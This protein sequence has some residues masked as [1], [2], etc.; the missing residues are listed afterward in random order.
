MSRPI[1]SWLAL[2]L[3]MLSL[4]TSPAGAALPPRPEG[5]VLDQAAVIPDA[6]EV[7]LDRKLRDY[8]K[9]TGR[10]IIVATVS[11]LDGLE[12]EEY[13]QKLAEAWGIG[14]AVTEEGVLLLVAPG[15]R[16]VRIHNGRGVQ[17]RLTDAMSGR[18]IRDAVVPMFKQ[19]NYGAGIASGVDR[20]IEVL[21]MSPAD[22]KAIAEAEAAASAQAGGDNEGTLAG[23]AFWI[24]LFIVFML[25]FGRRSQHGRRS[26]IDPGIVLWGASEVARHLSGRSGGSDFGSFGGGGSFGGFGGG[27]GGFDGGGASGDW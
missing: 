5:P 6:E 24:A 4:A 9:A 2:L 10:S 27:G 22:A 17:D 12:D 13:A 19:G 1:R 3:A 8:T 16:K 15:E 7:A 18:I 14:G 11:S 23:A 25:I 26:G 20:I 21:N